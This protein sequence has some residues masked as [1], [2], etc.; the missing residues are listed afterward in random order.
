MPMPNCAVHRVCR[1]SVGTRRRSC[2]TPRSAF[3]MAQSL[4]GTW[5]KSAPAPTVQQGKFRRIERHADGVRAELARWEARGPWRRPARPGRVGSW[6]CAA[7]RNMCF[8]GNPSEARVSPCYTGF[9]NVECHG[10][11]GQT[12]CRPMSTP[13]RDDGRTGSPLCRLL[14]SSAQP[15]KDPGVRFARRLTTPCGRGGHRQA[16]KGGGG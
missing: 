14:R 2:L 13:T 4:I 5:L 7:Q 1:K 16:G 6:A 12:A 11:R 10:K 8:K 9:R 15:D 3:A